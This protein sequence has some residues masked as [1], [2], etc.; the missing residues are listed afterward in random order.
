MEKRTLLVRLQGIVEE[1]SALRAGGATTR[2]ST[3]RSVF[4]TPARPSSA[5]S[6][7]TTAGSRRSA[8]ARAAA[9]A[10]ARGTHDARL[11]VSPAL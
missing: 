5:R 3:A 4:R 2:R 10:A 6:V 8:R 1:E 7:A 11:R 9:A